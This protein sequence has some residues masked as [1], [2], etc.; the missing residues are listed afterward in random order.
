MTVQAGPRDIVFLDSWYADRERGSGSAVAIGGLAAGLRHLGHRV[1]VLRPRARLPNHDLTRLFYNVGLRWRLR[2]LSPD[3]L[4]GF[5]F[6]GCFLSP[7]ARYPYVVAFKGVA[8]DERI[9]ETGW[10]RLRFGVLSRLERRNARRADRVVVTSQHSRRVAVREYGLDPAR[11]RIVPEGIDVEEWSSAPRRDVSSDGPGVVITIARQY[12][13]KNTAALI[14]A[15]A[16]VRREM[17]GV[18]LRVIGGGPELPRLRSLAASLGLGDGGVAFLGAAATRDAIVAEMTHADVFCLPSRQEGFGIVFL[19][20]MAAGLPIVA[21]NAGAIPE[22]APHGEV[23]LLVP[24]DDIRA[25]SDALLDL[26]RDRAL[27]DRLSAAGRAR[28]RRYGWPETARLFL[29]A[30]PGT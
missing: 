29:E 23:S 17:P 30:V 25:L 8:A 27:R 13:R 11:I 9:F 10:N 12:R 15:M 4:V 7:T 5:D 16:Q 3:L 2:D 22:V 24:P 18:Q 20:A 1:T 26:L 6:D 14:E 21:A 19:E 28:W